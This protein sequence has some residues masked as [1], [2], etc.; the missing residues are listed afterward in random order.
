[1]GQRNQTFN[2]DALLQLK[3]AGLVGASAAATVGGVAQ[4]L[5][6]GGG[7]PSATS[8]L[9]P[10]TLGWFDADL[11]VDVSAIE[12]GSSD[13]TYTL[14]FQLSNDSSF[15]TGV[16]EHCRL[17]LAH[18]SAAGVAPGVDTDAIVGRYVLC[19]SNQDPAGTLYKYCRLY[20]IVGGTVATG[21]NYTAFLAPENP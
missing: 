8:T 21:I 15:V 19:V 4:I 5:D 20:T 9:G 14:S 11:V 10:T 3:D 7:P 2:F 6:L 12:I 17:V 18:H 16:V 1:M 13:E